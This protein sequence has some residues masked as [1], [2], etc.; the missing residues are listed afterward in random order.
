MPTTAAPAPS[1]T[2]EPEPEIAPGAWLALLA[3]CV[4]VTT[5]Y[6]VLFYAFP[7]LAPIISAVEGWSLVHVTAAFSASQVVAGLGGALVGRWL[8]RSGPRWVMTLGAVG[9]VPALLGVALAPDLLWFTAAWLAAG[10]AMSGLFYPPAFAAVTRWFGARRVRGLTVLTLV[11]G[12]ASTIFAPLA[13][14]L[15]DALGWRGTY[16]V[17]AGVLAVVVIPLHA[18]AL[19]PSWHRPTAGTT[20]H[21]Q[22]GAADATG[23]EN[24]IGPILRSRAFIALTT[25]LTLAAFGAYA[26]VINLVPL[27]EERG[28]DASTAA[29]ALGV[30]GIG[31]VLGRLGYGPLVRHTGPLSRIVVILMV[32]AVSTALLALPAPVTVVML[33]ALLAGMA[34]GV[35]TLLQATAI[36]D[37]WGEARY[38]TLNGVMHTPL[39]LA[40]AL[41]PWAGAALAGLLG[42]YPAMFAALA[43]IGVVSVLAALF[44]RV[45]HPRGDDT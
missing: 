21:G 35:F 23:P 11:A 40:I 13:A 36:S 26:V 8:E 16:L 9:A 14:A 6:G 7:V 30:G 24:A 28:F 37:R 10:A 38:P 42:G 18:L 32:C 5:S 12:L 1:A 22:S 3:L 19:T 15:V 17:L 45:P 27:L 44:S 31:Q 25:A 39:M 2:P 33:L 43:A 20:P 4:T 41:A 29:W 34:R